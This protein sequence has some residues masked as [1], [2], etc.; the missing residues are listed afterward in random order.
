MSRFC[1]LDEEFLN[2]DAF[3]GALIAVELLGVSADA[4]ELVRQ[5]ANFI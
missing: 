5:H 1:D 4:E 2:H 3:E